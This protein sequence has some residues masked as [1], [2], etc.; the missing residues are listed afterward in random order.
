MIP[1]PFEYHAPKT[2]DEAV[3]LARRYGGES[4]FL[5]GGQSLLPLM[6]LRML[7]PGHLIDLNGLKGLE[8]IRM[9][10]GTFAIGALTRMADIETSEALR[11]DC[12]ILSEC[13]SQIADPLVR[14]L[15]TVGGN[16]CHADPSNDMP[17]VM[18]ASGAEMVI[19]GPRGERTVAAPDFFLD[20][21]T[22]A[23]GEGEILKELRLPATR[24]RGSAYAKLERQA[25]DFGIVGVAASLRLSPD[26][27]CAECG[28]GLTGAGPTVVKA[29][30]S[31]DAIKGTK[32]SR[33]EIAKAA[34]L[35]AEDSKPVG[36]LR[37]SAAYKQEMVAVMTRR[38]LTLALKRAGSC[39]R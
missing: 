33:S 1:R 34:A 13:A 18:V 8:Y 22:T 24:T 14:N 25:G 23:L 6:K 30:R 12:P 11:R 15:G 17:A 3:A 26:G 5:A 37:G 28:I 36:D 2:L 10:N 7:S 39:R 9:E 20:T 31:E 16:I 35:A 21:F 4:K 29:R 27:S 38:T 32:V 19:A